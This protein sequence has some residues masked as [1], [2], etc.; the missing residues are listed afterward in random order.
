MTLK[1]KIKE[2]FLEHTLALVVTPILILCGTT[3]WALMPILLSPLWTQVSPQ[4][5]QRILGLAFLSVAVLLT[6]VLVLRHRLKTQLKIMF[7]VFW[8][9]HANAFCPACQ[10]L[11]TNY[12]LHGYGAKN[13]SH[14]CIR[15]TKVV[16]IRDDTANF[17]PLET[18][19]AKVFRDM[20]TKRQGQCDLWL[21]KKQR[22]LPIPTRIGSARWLTSP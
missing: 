9:K 14:M 17:I 7:G 13:P 6:Y 8:D 20:V 2:Q 19:R 11:L 18:A 4:T 21:N 22:A 15:C 10:A 16:A 1:E 12:G 5:L 3:V